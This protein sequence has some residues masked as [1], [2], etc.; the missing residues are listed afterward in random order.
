[1]DL[2]AAME[3]YQDAFHIAKTDQ[4]P[5]RHAAILTRATRANAAKYCATEGLRPHGSR[6]AQQDRL[7]LPQ[8]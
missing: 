7:R 1:M 5:A 8:E 6:Q 4:H 3:E 2:E